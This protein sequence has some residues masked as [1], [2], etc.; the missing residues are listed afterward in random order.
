MQHKNRVNSIFLNKTADRIPMWY[1]GA[2]ETTQNLIQ[3]LGAD[4][5]DS[6]MDMLGIDFRTIRPRYNG[7]AMKIYEDGSC[8]TIWGVK[9][10]GL[11]YG[12]A[13]NHPLEAEEDIVNID[14]YNWPDSDLWDTGFSEEDKKVSENYCIIGGMWSPFFHDVIELMGLEK[15]FIDMYFNEKLVEAV[16]EKV[17]NFYYSISER[18]FRQNAGSTDIFFFGNDFGSQKGLLCSPGMWRKFFK[19]GIKKLVELGH[20][21]NVKTA[22]HSCGD[23]HEIIPDLIEMGLDILNPIQL[24]AENMD[25]AVLKKHYGKHI[26][27]FGGIDENVVLRNGTEENVRDETKRIIDCLGYDGKYIVAAS[28]DCLLPEIPVRNIWAMYD[29]AVKYQIK[30]DKHTLCRN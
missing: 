16:V 18:T 20:S 3:F 23:I 7:P 29:E 12:Q 27:F 17:F 11:Y 8:D 13:I 6:A 5:E 24:S 2:A 14:A 28:H 22:L 15:C 19:P 26:V 4:S 10:K 9:R 30:G 21:F 1:G 25:P